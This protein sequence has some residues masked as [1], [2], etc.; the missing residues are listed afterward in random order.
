MRNAH[1]RSWF[2]LAVLLL[3]SSPVL[4]K[5]TP[6]ACGAEPHVQCAVYDPNEVYQ[7]TTTVAKGTPTATL[8]ML[9]AGEKIEERGLGM[10]D[11]EGWAVSVNPQGI[12]LKPKREKP[13]TNFIVVTNLRQYMFELVESAKVPATWVL[14]FEYPDSRQREQDALDKDK[15]NVDAAIAKAGDMSPS[16]PVRNDRYVMRGDTDLAPTSLWDDGRFT[17]F[18]Y[19]TNRM[20]PAGF[21][22]TLPD[23]SEAVANT[24]SQGDTVIVPDVSK[25]FV[26]RAGQA[27]LEIRNDGYS[28]DR[29]Y[30]AAGTT[31][32]GT[33]RVLKGE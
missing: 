29:T 20:L 23:G 14:R 15:A 22:T 17:Y 12:M 13:A 18:K 7:I 6:Q 9:E 1:P 2:V 30:N 5:Y 10:G 19:A 4:A 31:V 8:I 25:T 26:L 11:G 28:A 27:V 33:F 21:Y 24:T 32:P 3:M 16:A